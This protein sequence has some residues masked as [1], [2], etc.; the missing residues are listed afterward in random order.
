[1][2]FR[3]VES[4]QVEVRGGDMFNLAHACYVLPEVETASHR[5]FRPSLSCSGTFGD[6]VSLEDTGQY[7]WTCSS[8]NEFAL[9]R[10][11]VSDLPMRCKFLFANT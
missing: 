10:I 6:V 11:A 5:R 1:M 2:L 4:V 8:F 3:L 9:Q 7:R